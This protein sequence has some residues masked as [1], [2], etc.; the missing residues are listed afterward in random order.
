MN[1]KSILT[2]A[3]LL[4]S[5]MTAGAQTTK[6][7]NVQTGDGQYRSFEVTPKLE[8]SWDLENYEENPPANPGPTPL[9]KLTKDS[10][11]GTIGIYNGVEAIVV[12]LTVDN[13]KTKYAIATKN[14]GAT[15][16]DE[17]AGTSP[18]NDKEYTVYELNGVLTRSSVPCYG[19]YYSRLELDKAYCYLNEIRTNKVW[20][21]PSLHEFYALMQLMDGPEHWDDAKKGRFLSFGEGNSKTT[22]FLPAAGISDWYSGVEEQGSIG[23]YW[24]GQEDFNT[25]LNSYMM[26]GD[27]NYETD[28]SGSCRMSVRLFCE[29]SENTQLENLTADSPVGAVGLLYGVEAMVIPNCD[30]L[31]ATLDRIAVAT[32]NFGA[33]STDPKDTLSYGTVFGPF[34]YTANDILYQQMGSNW[35]LPTVQ[36]AQNFVWYYSFIGAEL[37]PM[38]CPG[39]KA[40]SGEGVI[41]NYL[42]SGATYDG[43]EMYIIIENNGTYGTARMSTPEEW[44]SRLNN[45]YRVRPFCELPMAE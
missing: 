3:L 19:N 40:G 4:A 22:L 32:K 45:E 26:S 2:S 33:E 10:P 42:C 30:G 13:V 24:F 17:G 38:P 16:V 39:N 11:V 37:S 12:E 15:S 43:K 41:G 18:E 28:Y 35:R 14:V 27:N 7:L 9:A 36:E 5:F 34:D 8:L 31:N 6:Y 44:E 25:G 29:I 1:I 21:V 23:H 20:H